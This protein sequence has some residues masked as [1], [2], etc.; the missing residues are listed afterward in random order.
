MH[1]IIQLIDYLNDDENKPN[2]CD[3]VAEADWEVKEDDDESGT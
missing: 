3:Y 2:F 1:D